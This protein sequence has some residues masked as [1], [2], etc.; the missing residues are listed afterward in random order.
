M[1]LWQWGIYLLIFPGRTVCSVWVFRQHAE[2]RY[3]TVLTKQWVS[4][5]YTQVRVATFY[6]SEFKPVFIQT[7]KDRT[8]ARNYDFDCCATAQN[9][10]E[11]HKSKIM[12]MTWE[13]SCLYSYI[14][15]PKPVYVFPYMELHLCSFVLQELELTT[16]FKRKKCLMSVKH[17]NFNYTKLAERLLLTIMFLT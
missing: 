8:V 17:S 11:W 6:T 1:L 16:H 7:W 15:P 13:G 12:G 4:P 10:I 3:A 5:R 2:S 14:T 9:T